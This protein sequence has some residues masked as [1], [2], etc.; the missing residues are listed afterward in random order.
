MRLANK[1]AI[2]T[3]GGSGI[4]KTSAYLFAKEGAKVVVAQRTIT[5][6][7]EAVATINSRGGEA[8]FVRTDVTRASEVE[9]LIRATMDTF[10][11]ID[12]LFN[13]AGIGQRPS[14]IENTD[15]LVWDE[16]YAINVKGI[17]LAIKYAVP[18]MK[19]AGGG[20]IINTASIVGVRP[21]LSTAAYSSSKGAVIV[22]TKA[23]ALELAPHNIRVNCINPTATDTPLVRW[24]SAYDRDWGEY[25]KSIKS[26]IPLGRLAKPEDSAYAALYLASDE[27]SMLTGTCINVD[28]GRGI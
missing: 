9:H 17:F 21:G 16:I 22:L 12:I 10:G 27:S 5:T 28:G 25:Q 3:G 20:V 4:G 6:G 23:L 18:E 24:F 7:E 2:I 8:I 1:V 15:E 13:N 11:S 14:A 19:K 26:T